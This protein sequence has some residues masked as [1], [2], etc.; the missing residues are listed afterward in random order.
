M[1]V[2]TE[3]IMF[4]V[5]MGGGTAIV[6]GLIFLLMDMPKIPAL[7]LTTTV[8]VIFGSLPIMADAVRNASEADAEQYAFVKARTHD[9]RIA[10]AITTYTADGKLSLGE[11]SRIRDLADRYDTADQRE[12]LTGRRTHDC[13]SEAARSSIRASDITPERLAPFLTRGR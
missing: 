2:D 12:R 7:M 4:G 10:P 5:M 13:R 11:F 8:W 1:Y 3:V 9:C 6:F